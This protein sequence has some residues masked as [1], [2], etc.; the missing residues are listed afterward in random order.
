MYV[1]LNWISTENCHPSFKEQMHFPLLCLCHKN[2]NSLHLPLCKRLMI[3]SSEY[4]Q[5]LNLQP[6]CKSEDHAE[7]HFPICW[8]QKILS[9]SQTLDTFIVENTPT[10]DRNVAII[11]ETVSFL[12]LFY[13][14]YKMSSDSWNVGLEF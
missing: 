7:C 6:T 11:W 10:T 8:I 9:S 14:N 2:E 5:E 4:W 13:S 12:S 3:S 1:Y